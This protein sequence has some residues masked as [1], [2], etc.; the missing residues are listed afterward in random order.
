M[1]LFKSLPSISLYHLALKYNPTSMHKMML[2]TLCQ[3]QR[4]D[5]FVLFKK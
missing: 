5:K 1:S 4:F 2:R 3:V